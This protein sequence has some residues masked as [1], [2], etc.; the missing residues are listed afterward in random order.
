MSGPKID[1]VELERRKKEA[2]ERARQERLRQIRLATD[3]FNQTIQEIRAIG[4]KIKRDHTSD[5]LLVKE[6]NEMQMTIQNVSDLKDTY[7]SL[8]IDLTKTALPSEVDDILECA[9]VIKKQASSLEREYAGKIKQEFIRIKDFIE[10]GH[11]QRDYEIVSLAMMEERSDHAFVS[12]DFEFEKQIIAESKNIT[13]DLKL[14]SQSALDELSI[15]INSVEITYIDKKEAVALAKR[16]INAMLHGEAAVKKA[17]TEYNLAKVGMIERIKE[18]KDL[19]QEYL[20]EYVLFIDELNIMRR[21]KISITPKG[22]NMF[23]TIAQLEEEIR[24][25]REVSKQTNEQNYIRAQLNDVMQMFGYDLCEDIVLNEEQKGRHYSCQQIAGKTA[26]H[27]HVSDARQ[28][29]MEIIITENKKVDKKEDV[30]AVL[31][32]CTALDANEIEF[33][34][35]EQGRFCDMHPQMVEELRKRGVI[36]NGKSH[37]KTDIK[38]SKK[39]I[40]LISDE[41]LEQP[42]EDENKII[43]HPAIIKRRG[44]RLKEKAIKID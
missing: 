17:V 22:K 35:A 4:N 20:A 21:Q 42:I 2:L 3:T 5:I 10:A 8:L 30:S 27:I 40:H 33:L 38:Y 31:L 32:D 11:R 36:L 1:H 15:I 43:N 23:L 29:M 6:A 26:I 16:I 34:L 44:T 41:I 25:L 28:I 13:K 24:A 18:F 14:I 12:I 37:R 7:I 39:I 19:Y 9:A